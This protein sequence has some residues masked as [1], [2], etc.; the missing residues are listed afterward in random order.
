M[1]GVGQVFKEEGDAVVLGEEGDAAV[2]G[3]GVPSRDL[4][5]D[6]KV[7]VGAAVMMKAR[8]FTWEP[9]PQSKTVS[10]RVRY[11]HTAEAVPLVKRPLS[12]Y[13]ESYRK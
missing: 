12:L 6:K 7:F 2:F 3:D 9:L 4:K 11:R 1:I 13:R 8:G 10:R 5:R